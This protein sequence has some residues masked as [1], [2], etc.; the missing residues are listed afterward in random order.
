MHR[1]IKEGRRLSYAIK[2]IFIILFMKIQ[3]EVKHAIEITLTT[4]LYIPHN[5][6][7]RYKT[8]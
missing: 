5:R 8:L 4:T 1:T 6:T 7:Y 3:L 2:L